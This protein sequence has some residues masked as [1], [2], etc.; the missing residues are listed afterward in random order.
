[1][2]EGWNPLIPSGLP[3]AKAPS[4]DSLVGQGRKLGQ[5][6]RLETALVPATNFADGR[7]GG[8]GSIAAARR[9]HSLRVSW[10]VCQQ[11]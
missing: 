7:C 3:E 6:Q 10:R 1:M 8:R 2:G 4:E 5:R 9:K 11:W